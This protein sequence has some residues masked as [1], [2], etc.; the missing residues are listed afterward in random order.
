T[1]DETVRGIDEAARAGLEIVLS[2]VTCADNAADFPAFVELVAARW[3]R[4]RVALSVAAA[5]TDVVPLE[6]RIVPRYRDVMPHL[7][8]GVALARARGL[9]VSGFESM[10]GMPLCLVPREAA[11]AARFAAL[12][13]TP[14]DGGEFV[15]P[16]PCSRCALERR[17]FG[18]RRSYAALYGTGELAPVAASALA[19]GGGTGSSPSQP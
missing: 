11:D 16:E 2:F 14:P 5:S 1:F 12:A 9:A 8:A 13:E 17:C 4:A 3:P 19:D 18:V 10:C 6:P 15:K 7:A